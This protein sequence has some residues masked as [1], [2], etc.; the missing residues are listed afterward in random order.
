MDKQLKYLEEFLHLLQ[1]LDNVTYFGAKDF[2]M[3][4]ISQY[5]LRATA[6]IE[7]LLDSGISR[8]DHGIQETKE[9]FVYLDQLSEPIERLA[10]LETDANLY[11]VELRG[12]DSPTAEP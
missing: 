7:K 5:L 4:F 12:K 1:N 6:E 9:I 10:G 8:M 11:N 3:R 2:V